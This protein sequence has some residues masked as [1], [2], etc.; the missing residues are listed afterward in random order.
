MMTSVQLFLPRELLAWL[1]EESKKHG[2]AASDLARRI[3]DAA[4]EKEKR[5]S[6]K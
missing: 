2:I 6:T 3:I 5:C 1:R 4:R